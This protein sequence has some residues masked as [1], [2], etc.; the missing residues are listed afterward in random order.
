MP[1]KT[2]HQPRKDG[3][4][5][6]RHLQGRCIKKNIWS[7]SDFLKPARQL[8]NGEIVQS[9]KR[10]L[11]LG[12]ASNGD[13]AVQRLLCRGLQL[14][15]RKRRQDGFGRFARQPL[16]GD[17]IRQVACAAGRGRTARAGQADGPESIH[18]DAGFSSLII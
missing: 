11:K 6:C 10:C 17:M 14:T 2:C 9:A 5:R 3:P 1:D 4:H 16:P 8:R 7:H 18:Q 15:Q 12:K 13:D